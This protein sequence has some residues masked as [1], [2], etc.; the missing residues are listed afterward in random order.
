MTEVAGRDKGSRD[1]K[2]MR[3]YGSNQTIMKLVAREL[4]QRDFG[5]MFFWL[6]M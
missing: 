3:H 1:L 6:P 2:S 4:N 5:D